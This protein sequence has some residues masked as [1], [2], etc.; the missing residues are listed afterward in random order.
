MYR[1]V[2][3]LV[4]L[5]M[6]LFAVVPAAQAEKRVALVIGNG[7]YGKVGR[8]PN[9]ARDAAVMEAMLRAAG[10]GT[11]VA[12]RNLGRDAMRRSLRDFSDQVRDADIAVVFYAGHG[13]EVNG[14]NYLIPV[15]AA[16]ERDLDVEDEAVPLDR[17]SQVL[18]QAGRLRLVILD[19]CRDNPFIRSMQ[20]TVGSRSI[21]RGLAKV[22]VLTSNTLIA[23]AA[24]AGSTASDG[25]GANSPYTSALIKHLATPG[26]DV[27]LAFGRVRDEV[28]K[29]TKNKQEPFVYGSLGG[30][31]ITL[32]PGATPAISAPLPAAPSSGDADGVRICREVEGMSNAAV[33]RAMASKH[34]GTLGAECIAARLADL[35]RAEAAETAK[36]KADAAKGEAERVCADVRSEDNV[37]VLKAMAEKHRGTPAA[38]CIAARIGALGKQKAA[39]VVPDARATATATGNPSNARHG[40]IAYAPAIGARGWS[41]DY[42]T[43]SAAE[44]AALATCARYSSNPADC[45]TTISFS[46]GCGAVAV[47]FNTWMGGFG[48]R[49]GTREEAENRALQSCLGRTTE[50]RIRE[51][52]C[53]TGGSPSTSGSP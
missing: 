33:L 47:G 1:S 28:L 39:A 29:S 8:L 18:E 4:A 34:K 16:L 10:F 36:K 12:K 2:F 49:G 22:E 32:V 13:I 53:T 25:Q 52:A 43:R 19:A 24:K 40:A 37:S 44:Q 6:V 23:F 46:D 17:V 11:V 20:R 42:P 51:S 5:S 15:D 30:A 31:E 7:D 45:G 38:T 41:A 3:S 35:K 14:I 9:P 48:G 26:L 50:C 27:R 21:G